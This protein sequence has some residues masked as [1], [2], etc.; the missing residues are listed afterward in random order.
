M[1]NVYK[2]ELSFCIN[3]R[4]LVCLQGNILFSILV[5]LSLVNMGMHYEETMFS[6]LAI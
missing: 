6:G 1:L 2:G 4:F 3:I 5:C